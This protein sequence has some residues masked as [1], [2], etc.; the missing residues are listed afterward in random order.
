MIKIKNILT[1]KNVLNFAKMH[2]LINKYNFSVFKGYNNDILC[3]RKIYYSRMNY[4]EKI[5]NSK[6]SNEENVKGD[7]ENSESILRFSFKKY[8]NNR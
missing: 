5:N 8:F 6:K 2:Q 4:S 1:R 3:Y 7:I